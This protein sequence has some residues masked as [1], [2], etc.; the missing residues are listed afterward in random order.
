MLEQVRKPGAPLRFRAETDVVVDRDA[1]DPGAPVG[2][3][4]HPQPV[5]QPEAFAP[6]SRRGAGGLSTA[7]P[8]AGCRRPGLR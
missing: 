2:S 4:Q 8:L 5:V 6:R 7:G 3:Q 1:D